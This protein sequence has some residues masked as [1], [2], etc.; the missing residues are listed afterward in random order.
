MV[1][2]VGGASAGAG[3]RM[4]GIRPSMPMLRKTMPQNNANVP[5]LMSLLPERRLSCGQSSALSGRLASGHW[6]YPALPRRD[7]APDDVAD[8]VGDEQ[9]AR[10]VDRDAD[11]AAHGLA[12]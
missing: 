1:T 6:Y 4:A 11:R 2:C 9:G 7:D 8:V 12:V 10:L 3:C 5:V